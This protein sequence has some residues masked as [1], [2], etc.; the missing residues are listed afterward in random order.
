VKYIILRNAVHLQDLAI[1][2]HCRYI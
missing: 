1:L 2:F